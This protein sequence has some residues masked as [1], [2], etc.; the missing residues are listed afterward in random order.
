MRIL[1]IV[2][3]PLEGA[4]NRIRVEQFLPYLKLR[5]ITYKVRPFINRR[6]YRILYLPSR[7]IEKTFWFVMCTLN[8]ILDIIRALR[9]DII[10]IHR[11]V[12]PF[13]GPIIEAVL[14]KIGK[15][16]IFD[17]DD[18][19]FLPNTSR[20]NIY[21][22]MF[23]NPD[24]VHGIIRMSNLVIAGNE[25][26]GSYALRFN[27]NVIVIPSS[28]DTEKYRP[29]QTKVERDGI[30]V[31]WI[32]SNT[33]KVFLY[34]IEDVFVKLSRKFK[35]LSF[36][37]VGA[38]FECPRLNNVINKEWSLEDEI[39]DLQDFDIGIMP[40]PD[41]DWT[42]G[43]CGFKAILYMAL[44]IPAVCSSIGV[45]RTIIK[46][47]VNGFLAA[48]HDEWLDRLSKLIEDEALREKVGLEGRK[49]IEA[50][51]SVKANSSKFIEALT[52]VSDGK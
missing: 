29:M 49:T 44:G 35:N 3:Y 23:K 24:K 7:Y 50:F 42:R 13:G 43:K 28:I 40:M 52:S 45:N 33:T 8:R 41:N 48:G 6:F 27:K 32:G 1:F 36:K 38:K 47:G 4:S 37:I 18:A 30:V 26:L 9:Y 39:K 11:E 25:Y 46:D 2:P 31:G 12:Y 51:Y 34:D 21:I 17:F 14:Y 15:P 16:I 5:G 22:D 19:I 10:F 20:Q